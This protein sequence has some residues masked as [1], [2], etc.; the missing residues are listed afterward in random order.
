MSKVKMSNWG[1]VFYNNFGSLF[2][3]FI[4]AI[5]TDEGSAATWLFGLGA[6]HH[7]H[8]IVPL[9]ATTGPGGQLRRALQADAEVHWVG[10]VNTTAAAISAAADA[11]GTLDL[12]TDTR[13]VPA[14]Q[15]DSR[16]VAERDDLWMKQRLIPFVAVSISCLFGL[17]I[18]FF[19]FA[20]RRRISATGFTVMGCTNKLLT[21]LVNTLVWSLHASLPAQAREGCR[22][23]ASLH[24]PLLLRLLSG[25]LLC[26]AQKGIASLLFS[27][28]LRCVCW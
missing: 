20:T 8:D 11:A 25:R 12:R 18:S 7:T 23:P 9:L 17:G 15:P 6:F 19:G 13:F 24:Q 26:S 5:I 2:I 28:L 4:V 1:M 3:S 16:M 27:S 14:I 22:L 21:L 10:S